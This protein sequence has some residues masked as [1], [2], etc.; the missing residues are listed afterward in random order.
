MMQKNRKF[1]AKWE[2]I[3]ILLV[4]KTLW[5]KKKK[6]E[7]ERPPA[8]HIKAQPEPATTMQRSVR[9]DVRTQSHRIHFT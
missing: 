8:L 5:S 6:K 9:Q 3:E 7:P 1:H 2:Q 4:Q